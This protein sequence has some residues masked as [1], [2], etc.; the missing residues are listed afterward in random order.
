MKFLLKGRTNPAEILCRLNAQHGKNILSYVNVYDWYNKFSEDHKDVL[1]LL[2][3]HVWPPAV[4]HVNIY[5]IKKQKA[6]FG[7]KMNSSA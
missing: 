4:C 6:D 1:T 5:H 2:H 3:A 7:E